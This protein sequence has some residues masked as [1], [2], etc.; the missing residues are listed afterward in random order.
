MLSA[1][2]R[3]PKQFS[4]PDRLDIGRSPNRHL[5]FGSG[6]HFCLGAPLAHLEGQIAITTIL[7]KIPGLRPVEQS[8]LERPLWHPSTGLRMLKTLPVMF[9]KLIRAKPSGG[10]TLFE[11]Q[12]TTSRWPGAVWAGAG[13]SRGGKEYACTL[14][15]P[16]GNDP[17]RTGRSRIFCPPGKSDQE[18]KG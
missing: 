4:D 9:E 11:N 10:F 14:N 1:A 13:P 6:A 2:N 16:A 17:R 3:D 12:S 8:A 7:Q 15:H 18:G 5:A